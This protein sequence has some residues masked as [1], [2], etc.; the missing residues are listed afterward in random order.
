MI[1]QALRDEGSRIVKCDE[2][3]YYYTQERGYYKKLHKNHNEL[4][5]IFCKDKIA[6]EYV[7]R[8][9]KYTGL[10]KMF[11]AIVKS[12]PELTMKASSVNGFVCLGDGTM[13]DLKKHERIAC[14]QDVVFTSCLSYVPKEKNDALVE[15]IKQNLFYNPLD[16]NQ[17]DFLLNCFARAIGKHY[18][19][20]R[21][22]LMIGMANG[23]KGVIMNAMESA[24]AGLVGHFNTEDL[25]YK[26]GGADTAKSLSWALGVSK[27][28]IGFSN[29]VEMGE[30]CYLSGNLIKKGASGG[31]VMQGRTN[32]KDE[33]EF[34]LATT[35]FAAMNDLPLIKPLDEGVRNRLFTFNFQKAFVDKVTKPNYELQGDP[36]IKDKI[37]TIDWK[38]ALFWA[39]LDAY[40]PDMLDAPKECK[41][42]K[43]EMIEEESDEAKIKK[44]FA[45]AKINDYTKNMEYTSTNK[46]HKRVLSEG[47]VMTL[48]KLSTTMKRLGFPAKQK[49]KD[50]GKFKAYEIVMV[51]DKEKEEVVISKGECVM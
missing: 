51:N 35:L 41:E 4:Y 31:D 38:S 23:G 34:V 1:F 42:F 27:N 47:L 12:D 18:G 44:L 16:K 22:F 36:T 29:E 8:V 3:L 45:P 15:V 40:T 39:V 21:L 46:F 5:E 37:K 48:T 7:A 32:H 26:K 28:S 19:D 14:S 13:W 10:K 17:G 9:T 24:F 33:V 6:K 49:E 25:M 30:G 43:E 11:F 50:G 2:E 20:K